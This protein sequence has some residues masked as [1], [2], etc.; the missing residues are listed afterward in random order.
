MAIDHE[1]QEL[2]SDDARKRGNDFFTKRIFAE[3][4]TRMI[5]ERPLLT[6]ES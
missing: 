2:S 1:D 4:T 6:C 5:P 3:G